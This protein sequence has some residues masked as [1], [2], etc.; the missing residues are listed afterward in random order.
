MSVKRAV[1]VG[2]LLSIAWATPAQA[3]IYTWKFQASYATQAECASNGSAFVQS[4]E[5]DAYK[6]TGGTELYLGYIW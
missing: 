6:C 5:A 1:V 4:G 3:S 2:V